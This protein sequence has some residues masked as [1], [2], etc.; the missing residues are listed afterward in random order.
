[1]GAGSAA[2]VGADGSGARISPNRSGGVDDV[3]GTT[4][5]AGVGAY[6]GATAG[7]VVEKSGIGGGI[8][9]PRSAGVVGAG[10]VR[11][12][13]GVGVTGTEADGSG[14]VTV[15]TGSRA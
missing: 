3:G 6:A 2:G 12:G 4:G 15:S 9:R 14:G 13:A 8:V 10:G 7:G 1:M 11:V 5:T